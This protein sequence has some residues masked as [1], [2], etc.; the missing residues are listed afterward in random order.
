LMKPLVAHPQ[1]WLS[2]LCALKQK[3]ANILD[4]RIC[5]KVYLAL[6]ETQRLIYQKSS[7]ISMSR[8]RST[9]LLSCH[10]CIA[11]LMNVSAQEAV[12]K[13]KK[14]LTP[15]PADSGSAARDQAR[16]ARSCAIMVSS[17][18]RTAADDLPPKGGEP[19]H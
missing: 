9:C 10:C 16:F 18:V 4:S 2:T 8:T 15:P 6:L 7:G 11:S 3:R 13:T 14:R 1:Y 17:L 19:S 12:R 5:S